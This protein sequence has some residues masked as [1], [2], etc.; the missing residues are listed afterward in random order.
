VGLGGAYADPENPHE[1]AISKIARQ[2]MTRLHI[3][4]NQTIQF[5]R[6]QQGGSAPVRLLLGGGA[7]IMP[8][9][10]E[11][12]AEKLNMPVE[13]FNPF[14]NVPIDPAVDVNEL[15]K[16]A[17][18]FGEVVGLALRNLARCPV[19]LNLVPKSI[20]SRQ[21]FEQKKPYLA[22]AMVSLVL[23]VFAIGIFY[24]KSATIKKQSLAELQTKLNPL[25]KRV[26]ELDKQ[27]NSVQ[28]AK[29]EM[30]VYTSYLKDRFFWPEA[31][32]EMRNLLV[33]VEERNGTDGRDVGVWIEKFGTV[34]LPEAEEENAMPAGPTIPF[35]SLEWMRRNPEYA[36]RLFPQMYEAMLKAG[37]L[38]GPDGGNM[39]IAM[40]PR[41]A[42]TN[43]VT[44]NVKF[45]AV[46]LSNEN[47]PA[48]NGRLAFAV[49]E[50]FK[51][52]PFFDA[53]GTKLSGDLEEPEPLAHNA[54][55]FRF[56]MVLK[57]KNEMQL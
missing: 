40:K 19:E 10:R 3:Q 24:S 22:A 56:G 48:A 46:S 37:L 41:T 55:T 49:A 28:R 54:S 52:S 27:V 36:K 57:L 4:V 9:T 20:R 5:Y 18:G 6:G 30:D 39:Q 42:N 45:R 14:R 7:S 51:K 2:V 34:D 47:D 43:L 8:Y 25:Q 33:K 13:Y 53:D 23:V 26:E 38:N 21:A 12:F 35:G 29:Q 31:L 11:F 50:E 17:H 44:I 32:V 1:A 16:V 15:A